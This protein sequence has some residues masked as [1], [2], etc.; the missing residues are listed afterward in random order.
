MGKYEGRVARFRKKSKDRVGFGSARCFFSLLCSSTSSLMPIQFA[1]L[2]ATSKVPIEGVLHVENGASLSISRK[3]F[4]D[5]RLK[6]DAATAGSSFLIVVTPSDA[7]KFAHVVYSVLV[8][9]L[10]NSNRNVVVFVC[11]GC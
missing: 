5:I 7:N 3:G 11:N 8:C 4:V 6:F 2:D 1:L 9:V 10:I